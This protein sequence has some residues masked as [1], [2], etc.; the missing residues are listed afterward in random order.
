MFH[1]QIRLASSKANVFLRD[2]T[3]PRASTQVV[4]ACVAGWSGSSWPRHGRTAQTPGP[5]VLMPNDTG[6][7]SIV[8]GLCLTTM[9]CELRQESASNF[10]WRPTLSMP[11]LHTAP[12]PAFSPSP[13]DSRES[14]ENLWPRSGARPGGSKGEQPPERSSQ[15]RGYFN[16]GGDSR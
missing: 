11:S 5:R 12:V 14:A 7:A 13:P 9:N 1:E 6:D 3:S 8:T 2:R 15:A 10:R 16:G 4:T